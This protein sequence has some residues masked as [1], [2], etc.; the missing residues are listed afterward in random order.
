MDPLEIY[1]SLFIQ[2]YSIGRKIGVDWDRDK[3]RKKNS[4]TDNLVEIQVRVNDHDDS[5]TKANT[6][7]IVPKI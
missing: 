3:V 7:T 2:C 1:K 6:A 4:F 5:M